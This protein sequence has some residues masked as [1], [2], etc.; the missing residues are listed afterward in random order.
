MPHWHYPVNAL[1]MERV[2]VCVVWI[3]EI[4]I[5]TIDSKT[6]NN[7]AMAMVVSFTKQIAIVRSF[8]LRWHWCVVLRK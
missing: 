2:C 8:T 7:N 5:C 1:D 6:A 4:A 3:C